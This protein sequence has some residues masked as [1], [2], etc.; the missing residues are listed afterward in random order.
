MKNKKNPLVGSGQGTSTLSMSA[1]ET[2]MEQMSATMPK[3]ERPTFQKANWPTAGWS[4]RTPESQGMHASALAKMFKI[5]RHQ[6]VHS[7]AV[8]R[9]GYLVAEAY[10][11]RTNPELPQDMKSVTK[12]VT[13][14]LIGI[15][16]SEGKLESVNQQAADFFPEW[17]SDPSK[18]TITIKHLLS[19]TSGI[20]WD[21]NNEQSSTEMMYSPDWVQ[22]I[23]ERRARV[24][25]GTSFNYSNGDAHLLSAMLSRA[26]GETMYEY[27]QSR[28]FGPLGI[29]NTSW[30]HDPQ[31]RT[32]GAWAMA[33]TLRDMA[34]LGYLYLNEGEWEG[35]A[36][37]P[38]A[39]VHESLNKKVALNYSNGTQGGYGFYWW[40]KTLPQGL[41][42]GSKKAYEMFY[43]SGSGGRRIYVVPELQL[44]VA[45]TAE[46]DDA[47]MPER[48]LH[49]VVQAIRADNP[50]PENVI[51]G[52]ELERA[53]RLFKMEIES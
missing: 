16:L 24:A 48:L 27:A 14:A 46:S 25:P 13:S 17:E 1:A 2:Q 51:A 6:A 41:I 8:I 33:L 9:N 36:I 49:Q 50:L 10:N 3:A 15:A 34:K 12:S 21:N 31:G 29:T 30:N 40:S 18:S 7:V 37:I 43:A 32:I 44:V 53:V 28:L 11:D 5:F 38:K 22:Y 23:L 26:V 52:D 45:L 35:Q 42:K 47:D 4:M 39:W 19:M 20:A